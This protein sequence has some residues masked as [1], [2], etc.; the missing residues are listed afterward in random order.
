VSVE[1]RLNKQIRRKRP[2]PGE[3]QSFPK[4]GDVII[5]AGT[6]YYTG[7]TISRRNS[8]DIK[9]PYPLDKGEGGTGWNAD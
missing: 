4:A 5:P 7:G 3:L 8:K 6:P 2:G 1:N 9:F